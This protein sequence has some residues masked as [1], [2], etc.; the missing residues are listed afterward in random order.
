MS[1]H[2][3]M[4]QVAQ[5]LHVTLGMLFVLIPVAMNW[6]DPRL[7]GTSVGLLFALIK[8]FWWDL[9]YEDEG[10]SGGLSGSRQDFIYYCTGILVANGLLLI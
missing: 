4:N 2:L 6:H 7:I 5:T 8:E 3:S 9:K 10:T 1:V